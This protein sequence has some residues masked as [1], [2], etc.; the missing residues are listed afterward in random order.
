MEKLAADLAEE[1]GCAAT[2]LALGARP[3]A[4]ADLL[5]SPAWPAFCAALPTLLGRAEPGAVAATAA[6]AAGALREARSSGVACALGDLFVSLAGF[7]Y[8]AAAQPTASA[9]AAVPEAQQQPGGASPLEW[10][11][12]A[13]TP[14]GGTAWLRAWAAPATG[15]RVLARG[16]LEAGALAQLLAVCRAKAAGAAWP[17][18][19]A[20]AEAAAVVV[21][22]DALASGAGRRL[23]PLSLPALESSYANTCQVSVHTAAEWLAILPCTGALPSFC[24]R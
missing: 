7:I 14:G 17:R 15:A 2:V 22:G 13:D 1:H 5:E 9:P 18:M 24:A 21:I 10:M 20:A 4:A 8:Y 6:L 3:Y 12:A 19:S 16:L 11:C 23:F